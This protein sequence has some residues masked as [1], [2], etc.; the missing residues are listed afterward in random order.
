MGKSPPA[1][2][3]QLLREVGRNNP[4]GKNK[5]MIVDTG[6]SVEGILMPATEEGNMYNKRP[7]TLK[8]RAANGDLL[9]AGLEGLID[10]KCPG[11]N[12][13]SIII[14]GLSSHSSSELSQ[15]I[16][17]IHPLFSTGNWDFL[18][19]AKSRGGCAMIKYV[20]GTNKIE[21]IIPLEYCEADRTTYLNFESSRPKSTVNRVIQDLKNGLDTC[22]VDENTIALRVLSEVPAVKYLLHMEEGDSIDIGEMVCELKLGEEFSLEATKR[23]L[24]KDKRVMPRKIFS[25]THGHLGC[26]GINCEICRRKAG[27]RRGPENLVHSKHKERKRGFRWRLDVCTWDVRNL[28][29]DKYAFVLRDVASKTFHII[30]ATYRSD[31]TDLFVE[32]VEQLRSAPHAKGAEHQLVSYV[33]TDFDGVWRDDVKEFQRKMDSLGIIF[34]Y[35]PPER[36]EGGAESNI[37]VYEQTVKA[38]LMERNLPGQY[39]GQASKDAEFLMNRFPTMDS[40]KSP[41][42]DTVLPLEYL[43]NGFKSR[44]ELNRELNAYVTLGSVCLVHDQNKK[45]SD[46][47]SKIKIGISWGMVGEVNRFKC[48]YRGNTFRSSS[49]TVIGLPNNISYS[50]FLNLPDFQNRNCQGKIKDF[51][52]DL[53]EITSTPEPRHWVKDYITEIKMKDW[54]EGTEIDGESEFYIAR[55]TNPNLPQQDYVL[56]DKAYIGRKVEKSFKGYEIPFKGVVTNHDFDSA[57]GNSIWEVTFEDGDV[58]WYNH[59]ELMSILQPQMG[60]G[61]DCKEIAGENPDLMY[62][63]LAVDDNIRQEGNYHSKSSDTFQQVC[64]KLGLPKAWHKLYYYWLTE[65]ERKGLKYPFEK[66]KKNNWK[67]PVKWWRSPKGDSKFQSMVERLWEKNNQPKSIYLITESIG[68]LQNKNYSLPLRGVHLG[69]FA[70]R[71]GES[72]M[73]FVEK[74]TGK[75]LHVCAPTERILPPETVQD[76]VGRE[77]IEL[78][79][80]AWDLEMNS[81]GEY[82]AVT[83]NHS[84]EDL[85]RMGIIT[86]P[87]PTRMISDVKYSDGKFSKYKGRC[88]AQGFKMIKGVHYDG[89]TFSPTPNQYTNKILMGIKAGEQLECLSF[90]IKLAYTWG[91]REGNYKLAMSYP[92]GFKRY[93]SNGDELFMVSHRSQ[94]GMAPAGREWFKTRQ[95][96]LLKLL[97]NNEYS[98]YVTKSDPC[99]MNIVHWPDGK[100]EDF[101]IRDINTE[102]R[103]PD[104]HVIPN[105][106]LRL[107][108][109]L[110][111]GGAHFTTCLPTWMM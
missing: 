61:K 19:R 95:E 14:N 51:N 52:V 70:E 90:D 49:F 102:V 21:E 16:L 56:H 42:G 9:K 43:S 48:P 96:K 64:T 57:D 37:N 62:L 66:G 30:T 104:D 69:E 85:K 68:S 53:S 58:G 60:G 40:V 17:G 88:V 100:P 83:H 15:Y 74:S 109:R 79:V 84:K 86:T 12:G 25:A 87:I 6:S 81:L 24:K 27:N 18:W 111:R 22:F 8:C 7:S 35:S 72:R 82:G 11:H 67:V 44:A 2:R 71:K 13:E 101:K 89:K 103:D 38:I 36:K 65:H 108:E 32:W 10:L 29:G 93:D 73:T 76:A 4:V 54:K 45:G 5:R 110:R 77:D 59:L 41:D 55:K 20:D 75:V 106:F 1:K 97:N 98:A 94:Y 23:N 50:Q 92:R 63:S 28:E 34:T 47:G 99:L 26:S 39:W 105:P 80:E 46:L 91:E 3:E 78:L 33:K 107:L 31:F